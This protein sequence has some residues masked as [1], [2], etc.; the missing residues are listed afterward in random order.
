MNKNSN[1]N[2][3]ITFALGGV[4]GFALSRKVYSKNIREKK[5]KLESNAAVICRLDEWIDILHFGKKIE[6]YLKEKGYHSVLIYGMGRFGR[7]LLDELENSDIDVP[8]AIDQNAKNKFEDVRVISPDDEF[9]KADC[10]VVT[11]LTGINEIKKMLRD[12]AGCDI[13]SLDELFMQL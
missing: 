11:P 12:K 2:I 7:I 8:A 9:P 6:D 1:S 3:A 4:L 13:L 5:K 10:I